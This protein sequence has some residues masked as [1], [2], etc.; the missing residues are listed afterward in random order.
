MTQSRQL[1]AIMFTD[2]VGYTALM[3]A[4]EK[5]AFDLLQKNRDLQKPIIEHWRGK[6]IKE[7]GDGM[8]ASFNSVSDSVYAAMDIQEKLHAE[9][10]FQLRIG[11]HLGEVV[12]ENN[13]VFGDGVNIASRI[14]ATAEPGTIYVSETVH[15]NLY[16]KSGISSVFVKQENLKNVREPV[17]MYE[18]YDPEKHQTLH[19]NES[20]QSINGSEKSIAI[21]P[22]VNMSNDPDQ[23]YFSDGMAE[24]I[25]NALARIKELKVAG[26]TSS[27]QFKGKNID[28]REVGKKLGVANV[29]EGSVRK[30]GN[31]LRIT[32]QLVDIK[33]GFHLWSERYDRDVEDIL[34]IQEEIALAITDK[35]KLTLLDEDLE[36][37]TK[38]CA[39][40]PEAFQ[41]YLQARFL[42]NKRTDEGMA[43]SVR[44]FQKAIEKDPEYAIAWAGLADSYN[45]L[46]EHSKEA[47]KELYAK[48]NAAAQKALEI[49]SDVAEAHISL[50]SLLMLEKH[51]WVN[52]GKEFRLGIQ[53][54]PD[55]VTGHHWYS[56][57]LLGMGYLEEALKSISK[58]IELDPVTFTM[59]KDKGVIYYYLRQYEQ[60]IAL[61]N[62]ALEL[63]PKNSGSYRL[64]SLAFMALGK[65]DQALAANKTW[66]EMTGFH[67]KST[68]AKALILASSGEKDQAREIVE[69]YD[70]DARAKGEDFRGLAL[71]YLALDDQDKAF[72]LL[73]KSIDEGELSMSSLQ[74]DPKLDPLRTD[75]RY[76]ELVK[77]M[78]F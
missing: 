48:S 59:V 47:R 36:V 39:H 35:L 23:E 30:Y 10:V 3:G 49:D 52:A 16:N 77:K 20:S 68:V 4:S 32:A 24:E 5:R 31:H 15:D 46:A 54:K 71:V 43:T 41:F 61:A 55:Y 62:T 51:D 12:F 28:L 58:A 38:C 66:D 64:I 76:Q 11:I 67:F 63:D 17:R 73:E 26:R 1:A 33:N 37:I 40:D 18:V 7:L 8:L 27:F 34:T 9:N 70:E 78:G 65:F 42:W 21:L 75:P 56:E 29:L 72:Q 6:L 50:A 19:R 25:L 53:L 60:A 14:Q 74:V 44:Y 57:W 45:L 22:F 2:I 69:S 13:D